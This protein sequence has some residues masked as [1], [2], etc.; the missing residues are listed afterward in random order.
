MRAHVASDACMLPETRHVR[1]PSKEDSSFCPG[2]FVPLYCFLTLMIDI[3]RVGPF[4]D[5]V[6]ARLRTGA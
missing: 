5:F 3:I 4:S 6:S 1:F 2:Q